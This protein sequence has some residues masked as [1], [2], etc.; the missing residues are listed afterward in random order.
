MDQENK[1]RPS[2]QGQQRKAQNINHR[3]P[4]RYDE[5]GN[6]IPPK[7]R[8]PVRYDENGNPIPPKKRPPVRYDENGNPIP[9][10][11]REGQRP[12]R[13]TSGY[14]TY[15]ENENQFVDREASLKDRDE[16]MN[17]RE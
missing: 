16:D 13:A 9:R 14:D 17:E 5:N 1:R 2:E 10:Q 8:P 3:P 15:Q 6:P 12:P 7:K 11:H 4:V